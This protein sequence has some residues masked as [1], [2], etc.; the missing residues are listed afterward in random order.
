M[1]SLENAAAPVPLPC[2]SPAGRGLNLGS[3]PTTHEINFRKR[4]FGERGFG[5]LQG[6][7][8]HGNANDPAEELA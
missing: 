6:A 7:G 2:G 3:R 8:D 4:R 1:I 5:F